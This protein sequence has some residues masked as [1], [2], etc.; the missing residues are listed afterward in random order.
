MP[1]EWDEA[2]NR[3]NRKKHEPGFETAALVF[4][5]PYALTQRDFSQDEEELPAA[6]LPSA[7]DR[8]GRRKA[9]GRA[10][11]PAGPHGHFP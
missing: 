3:A 1:F 8:D 11:H 4:D 2:K 9:G 6:E 5:D 10:G 7:D